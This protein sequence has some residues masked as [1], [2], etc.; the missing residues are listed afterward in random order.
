[1][2]V[3]LIEA[4]Y[5]PTIEFFI[6]L[7]DSEVLRLEAHENY[8]KQSFRNRTVIMGAN[9]VQILVVPVKKTGKKIK[10]REVE[11]DYSENWHCQHWKTIQSAYGKAPFYAY[12]A[13]YFRQILFKRHKFLFDLN[14]DLMRLCLKLLQVE[15]PVELSQ[16]FLPFTLEPSDGIKDMRAQIHPKKKGQQVKKVTFVEYDQVFGRDFVKNLSII[17]LLFCEGRNSLQILKNG[18]AGL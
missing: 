2:S 15:R 18:L 3:M 12:F 9:K 8:E 4:Q 17:D 13:E 14:V 1:M 16:E 10:A 6:N 5:L 7:V 11:I